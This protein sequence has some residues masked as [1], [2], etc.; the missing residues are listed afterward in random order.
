[1]NPATKA[2]GPVL[3]YCVLCTTSALLQYYWFM[4]AAVEAAFL[5]VCVREYVA[6]LW[7]LCC[8]KELLVHR[9]VCDAEQL[10]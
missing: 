6:L 1:M 3:L 5:A 7:V 9:T 8:V 10:P 4:R 2:L